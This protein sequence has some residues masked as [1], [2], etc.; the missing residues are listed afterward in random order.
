MLINI[1]QDGKAVREI[2]LEQ[3]KFEFHN[4]M[5]PSSTLYWTAGMKEWVR[6]DQ[7]P[8]LYEETSKAIKEERLGVNWLYRQIDARRSF[9]DTGKLSSPTAKEKWLNVL[10]LTGLTLVYIFAFLLFISTITTRDQNHNPFLGFLFGLI[11]FRRIFRLQSESIIL[12]NQ[13]IKFHVF[14]LKSSF[15]ACLRWFLYLTPVYIVAVMD[16]ETASEFG[17]NMGK[18]L[19]LSICTIACSVDA[20]LW[21]WR[22]RNQFSASGYPKKNLAWAY[23]GGIGLPLSLIYLFAFFIPVFQNSMQRAQAIVE[24]A[25]FPKPRLVPTSENASSPSEQENIYSQNEEKPSSKDDIDLLKVKAEQGDANAQFNLG[26]RYFN[27]DGVIE[28]DVEA[29]KWY[30]KAAVQGYTEA[31]V[32][33]GICYA[34][35]GDDAQAVDWYRKAADQGIAQAQLNLGQCYSK[36]EGVAKDEKEALEWY[37]KAAL[38]GFAEAQHNLGVSYRDGKGVTKNDVEAVKWF[39]KAAE[40]GVTEA[41]HNLGVCYYKGEG[42]AKDYVEAY[43]FFSLAGEHIGQSRKA[44]V[45]LKKGMTSMEVAK[46]ERRAN[47]LQSQ[48]SAK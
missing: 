38:Q 19:G 17:K 20:P 34:L 15:L 36:G 31:Q 32:N 40:Q 25:K 26:N 9:G 27:G 8:E 45:L 41:Q 1:K 2:S 3:L 10:S 43:A 46:G 12:K 48:I 47:E 4:K 23:V 29:V 13:I 24:A 7:L 11:L 42:V 5:I 35:A 37:R 18:T 16:A 44:L 39:F 22:K 14:Y 6:L 28:D 30:H 21:V 33:L